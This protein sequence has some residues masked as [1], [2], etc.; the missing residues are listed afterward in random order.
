L[1]NI[2]ASPLEIVRFLYKWITKRILASRKFPSIILENRTNS[3]SLEVHGEQCPNAESR[4]LLSEEK[5]ELGMRKVLI[6][7][8]YSEQDICSVKETLI[9]VSEE[10]CR[11]GLGQLRF[12]EDTLEKELLRFGAYGGHHMGTARM[13]TDPKTSVVDRNC[14]VHN[15]TN[16]FIAGSAVFPTSSQANPT[17]TVTALAVRLSDHIAKLLKPTF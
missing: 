1:A 16:L 2:F 7:W 15:V 12:D 10:L 6:D 8:R 4:V 17:L 11:L 3:F 13:G 14:K 9:A 5:D